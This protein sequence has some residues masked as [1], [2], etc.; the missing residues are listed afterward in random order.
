MD[1]FNEL[2]KTLT[3]LKI[4]QIYGDWTECI[5]EQIWDEH[6]EAN[7][8]FVIGELDID[9][10][11]HFET[12]VSVIEIYDKYMGIRSITNV[13]SEQSTASDCY[14]YL[15]FFEMKPVTITTYVKA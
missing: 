7:Y 6:F 12:S 4:H 2:L 11:R 15:E 13:Y 3:E 9:K 5:P 1:K 8:D 14:E 10:H